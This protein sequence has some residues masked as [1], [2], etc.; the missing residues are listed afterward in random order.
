MWIET[1]D[2]VL[3]VWDVWFDDVGAD[4]VHDDVELKGVREEDC[5]TDYKLVEGLA[6]SIP[7]S[8]DKLCC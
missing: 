5:Q 3:P 7:G 8:V 1:V 6:G 2:I 4:D